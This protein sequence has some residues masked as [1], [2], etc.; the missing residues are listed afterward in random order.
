M[1][2]EADRKASRGV[3]KQQKVST[4]RAEIWLADRQVHEY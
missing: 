4:K 3:G 1:L 2:K